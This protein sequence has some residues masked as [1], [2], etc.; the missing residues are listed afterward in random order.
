MRTLVLFVV[1]F[2]IGILLTAPLDRWVLPAIRGPLAEAGAELRVDGLRFA[3]PAGIRATGV[4]IDTRGAG[5]E[6]D[7]LYVGLT[8]SFEANACGGH[9]SGTL[10]R[11]SVRI[12]LTAVD[13]SKCLR[14]GKLSLQSTLDGKMTFDGIDLLRPAV[15]ESASADIDVT[16]PGGIFR[17]I[18][19]H[20]GKDGADLPLGE[21][22]FTDL[23]LKAKLAGGQ[24]TVAEGHTMASGVE[25]QVVGGAV[26]PGSR[27][28]L[29]VDFRARQVED[30]PRSRALIGL[31][32][33]AALDGS[34][35]RNYR[36]IGSLASP[37][38]VA[39]D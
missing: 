21:W 11:Q 6:L 15:S 33:K 4:G 36:V 34:G 24:L 39:V 16:S 19:E 23:V 7:D 35:W 10:G 38:I 1:A 25:W 31:M 22:E 37:R 29:R 13:P 18:L 30:T 5:L 26:P 3:L 20:A 9:L 27:S 14:I 17:G 8:R 12:D 2:A 32:P 28:G